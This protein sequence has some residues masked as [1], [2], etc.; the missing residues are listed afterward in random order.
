MASTQVLLRGGVDFSSAR[1][2]IH[3]AHDMVVLQRGDDRIVVDF[4][5]SPLGRAVYDITIHFGGE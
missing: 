1:M 4:A 3:E 2:S 5:D